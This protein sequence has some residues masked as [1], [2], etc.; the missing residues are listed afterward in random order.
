[1]AKKKAKKKPDDFTVI[2]LVAVLAIFIAFT[3]GFVKVH[4]DKKQKEAQYSELSSILESQTN[5][6]SEL[7]ETIKNGIE[8]ELAED[9]AQQDGYV[10]PNQHVYVDIT[11]GSKN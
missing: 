4:S 9:Y 5:E 10:K 3:V 8:D 6:N 2:V 11:P 1:M 7:K